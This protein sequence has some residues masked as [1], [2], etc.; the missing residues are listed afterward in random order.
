MMKWIREFC[1][2]ESSRDY[3]ALVGCPSVVAAVLVV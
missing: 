2:F 3:P 1:S